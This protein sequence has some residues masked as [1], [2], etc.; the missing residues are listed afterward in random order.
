ME[1]EDIAATPDRSREE[2]GRKPPRSPLQTQW[3]H[4][5]RLFHQPGSD[6]SSV[7]EDDERLAKFVLAM[8]QK[9]LVQERGELVERSNLRL[10]WL[11]PYIVD[12]DAVKKRLDAASVTGAVPATG[13]AP[14]K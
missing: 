10:E 5:Q 12:L 2:S 6:R 8:T 14:T 13:P 7:L 11:S 4:T 3:S 1:S 9:S